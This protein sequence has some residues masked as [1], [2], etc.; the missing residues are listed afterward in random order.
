V[1]TPTKR[2]PDGIGFGSRVLNGIFTNAVSSDRCASVK[3]SSRLL[4][5]INPLITITATTEAITKQVIM[6][7]RFV[8]WVGWCCVIP[9]PSDSLIDSP[10]DRPGETLSN[11]TTGRV[12]LLGLLLETAMSS[13]LPGPDVKRVQK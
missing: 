4:E 9:S 6:P 12:E 7:A 8:H 5:R 3:R 10:T 1:I 13:R 11:E 2:A